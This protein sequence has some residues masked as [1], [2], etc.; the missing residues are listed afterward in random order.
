[1][2][3]VK[4]HLKTIAYALVLALL[5]AGTTLARALVLADDSPSSTAAGTI[6]TNHAEATYEDESGTGF[7]TVSQTISVMVLPVAAL[8]VMPRETNPS[9]TVAPNERITRPFQICNTG[10]TPDIYTIIAADASAPAEI[11]NLY[12]DTD[13]SATLT[14]ADLLIHTNETMSPRLAPGKCMGVLAIIDTKT[15]AA[16]SL[17][18]LH[19]TARSNVVTTAGGTTM[20]QSTG[21]IINA[22]GD[23]ARLTSPDNPQLPPVKLIENKDRAVAATGQTLDYSISFRNHGQTSARRLRVTDNLPAG[24]EYVANSLRLGTR[25]LTDTEDADE[26]TANAKSIVVRLSEVAPEELVQITFKARLTGDVASG[27]GIINNAIIT[28]EN[29]PATKTSDAIAVVDPFGTIYAG[30]SKGSVRIGGARVTLLTNQS[31]GSALSLPANQGFAPN[32][33][34]DNPFLTDAQGHFAFALT[35]GQLGT[36]AQ[37]A[38]YFIG[39]TAQN[40]RARLLDI[41]LRPSASIAGLFEATVRA[42]DNQPVARGGSFELTTENIQLENIAS[43]ALNI[44]LFENSALEITKTADKQRAEVGD[45]I[46]YRVEVRNATAAPIHNVRVADQLPPSFHY[47][48][49]TARLQTSAA[50]NARDLEPVANGNSLLFHIN[51][52]GAGEQATISYRTRIGANAADGEQI[53]S[54]TASGTYL[55]GEE[56]TTALARASVIVGRG[57]FSTRQLIIGRI[58]EDANSNEKFDDG[59]KPLAGVRVYLNNGQSVLTDS[60]GQYNIPSTGEGSLV[61]SIDPITIPQGLFLADDNRRANHSWTRLLRTPLGGGALLRQNFALVSSGDHDSNDASAYKTS[62]AAQQ[63]NDGLAITTDTLAPTITQP[64]QEVASINAKAKRKAV[65]KTNPQFAAANATTIAA[66]T[67]TTTTTTKPLASGTYELASTELIKP[68][69]PGDVLIVSPGADEVVMT[70]ALS[71]EARVHESWTVQT[72]VNGERITDA[73][74]GVRRVD[75]KNEV[76]TFGFVGINL[77][78]GPNKIKVTAINADGKA[79]RTIEQIVYGRGA[80]KRLEI[81]ADKNTVQAGGRDSTLVRVRAFDQWNHPAADGQL[82]L[83]TSAGRLVKS[84]GE[85]SDNTQAQTSNSSTSNAKTNADGNAADIASQEQQ[86]ETA[87]QQVVTLSG[88]EAVVQLYAENSPEAAKLHATTGDADARAEVRFTPEVRPSIL[89]GLAEVS[90]GRAAPEISQHNDDATT[91][92]RLAFFY[93]GSFFSD[94]NL[95]TLAYDSARPLNRTAGRDRLFQLDPLDRAYPIF[96]DSSTRFEDAQSNSKLYA[97]L[98]RNRSYALFGDFRADM[99]NLSLSGYARKLTG[100]KLHAENSR[101][102]FFTVTGARPDTTFARD[103]IAGGTLSL[104]RLSNGG[105]LPGSETVV[106]EVRDRRNPEIILSRETLARSIDYNLNPTTGEIFF[107]RP[108]STFDYQ[109]NLVQTV[110][111]YEHQSNGMSSAVYTARAQKHF[112]SL[113][114]RLG[115]SALDQ[116][117]GEFGSFMLGGIDGEKSLPN[118]GRLKFEYATSRGRIVG[119]GNVFNQSGA[120]DEHNGNAFR[121][122]LEQP[123]GFYEAT[124]RANYSRADANYLNP[125]GA[126]IAPGAERAAVSIDLKPRASRT[127]HLGLL[128][129]RNRTANVNNNRVTASLGW[130]ETW[131]ENFRTFFNYDYRKLNDTAGGKETTSNLLTVGAEYKPTDKIELSVKREQNIGGEADPTYPDQTTFSASYRVNQLTRIF[132]T[133]RLASAPIV[134]IADVAATGFASTNSRRETAIGIETK[135]WQHTALNGRYQIE[136]GING[137][138]SFAVIGL[139][140]NLPVSKTLSLDLG[141]ERG[142]HLAGAGQSYDNASVGFSWQ[143]LENFRSSARYELRNRNGFGQAITIGAAGKLTDSL[144]ALARLQWSRAVFNARGSSSLNGTAALAYRPLDSDRA[145]LLFSYTRRSLQQDADARALA[146]TDRSDTLASDGMY[147][148]TKNLEL[149]GRFALKFSANG[150][151]AFAYT[152]ALTYMAQARAQERI[153]RYLDFAGEMRFLAQPSSQTSRASYGAELGFWAIPDLRLGLG[154]NFTNATEPQGSRIFNARRGFYFTISSKLSNLF[155]LFG[156]SRAGIAASENAASSSSQPST[157]G[158]QH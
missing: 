133:E 53:N 12:F 71:L 142:F 17:L 156:T 129:E 137:A 109:L 110:I 97:R 18:T 77:R 35:P 52:L 116:R 114:L 65:V 147:Q 132:L 140:N 94:K 34:N 3:T 74:I 91:R 127:L 6:I 24:L 138:D 10:N 2:L 107:L 59:D 128:D 61:V 9:A 19:L 144:T 126:T 143:P 80:A 120:N 102:D 20:A 139:Q 63:A 121:A 155:D 44:P 62:L 57:V 1:M 33:P 130:N 88:G 152:S 66:T 154:Y 73:S 149:Y 153:N 45:I 21:T 103:V 40:Y 72:E 69:A 67:T 11:I 55:S 15:I 118:K 83:E 43:L 7:A 108:I 14:D 158:E 58:F 134:P 64:R 98:D 151:N 56:A 60:A 76:S 104:A 46:S 37:P 90:I 36:T 111:T 141:Y 115:F 95:L 49:N 100:V 23:G 42:L 68:V 38:H 26:G 48:A 119:G 106:L 124:L 81:V 54:A 84:T 99:D 31:A 78:P 75:H 79:E 16:Q 112:E 41:T 8:A 5:V 105:I 101:G 87:K 39:V 25:S 29:I 28:G 13:A 123:L 136:N 148:A 85:K 89:V 145:A 22:V 150:D 146:T 117:Q 27:T 93:R 157:A 32:E 70:P 135:V 30:R 113:G 51:D 92:S 122:D 47:A 125:F 50:A 4:V 86:N 131:R 82:A 96:G